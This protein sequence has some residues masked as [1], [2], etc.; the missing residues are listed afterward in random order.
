MDELTPMLKQYFEQKEECSGAL[1]L[2][3]VGDFYESYGSDAEILAKTLEMTLTSRE[4]GQKRLPMAGFPYHSIDHHLPALL[5][6]GYK[7]AISEQIEDPKQAK[8]LVKRAI[9][10]VMTS[11]TIIEPELLEGRKN[12]YLASVIIEGSNLGLAWADVSTGEFKC[13]I[14]SSLNKER[15]FDELAVLSPREVLLRQDCIREEFLEYFSLYKIPV[16]VRSNEEELFHLPETSIPSVCHEAANMI[17]GYLLHVLKTDNLFLK[18]L[19]FEERS[20]HMVLDRITAYNLELVTARD[21]GAGGKKGGTL[22]E[23]L[24]ETLTAMGGRLLRLWLERP[25]LRVEEIIERQEA[26]RSFYDTLLLLRNLRGLLGDIPDIERVAGKIIYGSANGRDLGAIKRALEVIPKCIEVIESQKVIS[27]LVAKIRDG[28]PSCEDLLEILSKA[29]A[30]APPLSIRE[31]GIIRSGYSQ[32]LDDLRKGVEEAK[33]WIAEM[34]ERE[35]L[36]TGIKSLKVGYNQVFGYYLEVTKS[37][38]HLVPPNYIRKQTLVN[39]ERYITEELKKYEG[40]VLGAE[41]KIKTLEYQLFVDI[42]TK[43]AENS[44]RLRTLAEALAQLDVIASLAYTAHN[45]GYVCPIVENS[46]TIEIKEG[47]HPVLLQAL[48]V[49]FVPNDV[50]LD[51]EYNKLLIITGPNMGGKSTYLRSTA[52]IVI[53]A[54][55]GGFVPAREARIGV[56]DRIFTRVGASDDIRGGQSTFMVEM[57]ET[58]QILKFATNRSLVLLDEVGRGTSTFDGLSIAWA[59]A[60]YLHQKD[61]IGARTL[62]ATHFHELTELE[63]CSEGVKNYRVTVKEKG[64]DVV[65]LHRIE[66]GASDKSYGIH[67][68]QLAGFPEDVLKRARTLLNELEENEFVVIETRRSKKRDEGTDGCLG[69]LSLFSSIHPMLEELQGINICEITPIEALNRLDEWQRK[70]NSYV[71]S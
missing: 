71:S 64:K 18:P 33:E 5:E 13:T 67:V 4:S 35:R 2:F 32:D 62:F 55:M 34:E 24:D 56:V 20:S 30:D 19:S 1:L 36:A 39:G 65:F 46:S 3:R 7:V 10:R 37:N 22:L 41:E 29:I 11:G 48:G 28:I 60:E 61:K 70:L 57:N 38:I 40:E 16:V 63:A 47:K 15:L 42:R 31:G 68:A 54:Q 6:K 23:V 17:M 44:G 9:V 14:F 45:N 58:A 49:S 50:L 69:Q 52:L 26:V 66:R 25:L 8:G 43:L 51:T 59:V 21:Y 12:H 53:M 27:S